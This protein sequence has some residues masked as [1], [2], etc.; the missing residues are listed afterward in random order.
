MNFVS[1]RN[2]TSIFWNVDSI[3]KKKQINDVKFKERGY[4]LHYF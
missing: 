1:G 2:V 4:F 3:T